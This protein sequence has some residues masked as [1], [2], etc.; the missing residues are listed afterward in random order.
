MVVKTFQKCRGEETKLNG[1]HERLLLSTRAFVASSIDANSLTTSFCLVWHS[2]LVK[3]Q[4][5]EVCIILC[6]MHNIICIG[7]VHDWGTPT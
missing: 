6:I 1:S 4:T 7:Y 3:R 5:I 2:T